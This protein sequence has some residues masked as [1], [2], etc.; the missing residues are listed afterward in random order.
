MKRLCSL[1][2]SVSICLGVF[3]DSLGY[4]G[5]V[6]G[7]GN[8]KPATEKLWEKQLKN[9]INKKTRGNSEKLYLVSYEYQGEIT[10]TD[11]LNSIVDLMFADSAY[12]AL[13]GP[14]YDFTINT[15]SFVKD[16]LKQ[17][18]NDFIRIDT[19]LLN[20][21]KE[22]QMHFTEMI[23]YD[24][25]VYLVNIK[26]L[27]NGNAFSSPALATDSDGILFDMIGT[28]IIEEPKLNTFS[29]ENGK[30]NIIQASKNP[31]PKN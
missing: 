20:L 1:I 16:S 10:S 25:N 23:E 27:Y 26:W 24:M 11:K 15:I 5:S 18:E 2:L 4:N 6:P 13:T 30:Q 7:S 9:F 31:I 3:A 21:K 19:A 29:N 28:Y 14:D 12:M 8:D 17:L 22:V